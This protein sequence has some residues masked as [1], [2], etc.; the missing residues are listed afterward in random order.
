MRRT[1]VPME[2]G[3]DSLQSR[4]G[5]LLAAHRRRL[6][7]TQEQLAELAGISID[8]IRKLEGGSSGASF[9]MIEKIATALELDPAE[10]F[11]TDIRSG[12]FS[13]GKFNE[14]SLKLA[15]LSANELAWI[16]DLLDVALRAKP[17]SAMDE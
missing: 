12:A 13:R 6:G 16:S 7:Y 2:I 5:R 11:T 9:P 3:M 1:A 4:F 17:T 15:A 14:I 8:T 10:L